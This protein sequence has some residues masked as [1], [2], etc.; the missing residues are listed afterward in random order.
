MLWGYIRVTCRANEVQACMDAEVGFLVS[1]GLL[2]LPH[3]SFMLVVDEFDDRQPR[4]P[5]VNVVAKSRGVD[6]SKLDLELTL[7]ELGLEN[8]D[9]S[10][11]VELLVMPLA[12]T[13][14]GR[15]F[16][17]EEGVD[18]RRLAET[19]F[20]CALLALLTVRNRSQLTDNHN[21]EVSTALCDDFV[22]LL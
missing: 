19:G 1:L 22:P 2:L 12:V 13:L 8:F 10:Q 4:I 15:E 20:T 6:D 21:G 7:L 11:L 18:Q 17:R 14:R 5:V 9:L 16:G 3:V